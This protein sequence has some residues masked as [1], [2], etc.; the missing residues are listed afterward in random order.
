MLCL[1]FFKFTCL[2][3]RRLWPQQS[4]SYPEPWMAAS[5]WTWQGSPRVDMPVTE[6]LPPAGCLHVWLCW[7]AWHIC[8]AAVW[9]CHQQPWHGRDLDMLACRH[10]RHYGTPAALACC[11]AGGLAMLALQQHGRAR[12]PW[13]GC[14]PVSLTWPHTIILGTTGAL[15]CW[16][17]VD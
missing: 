5:S 11:C 2:W 15:A 12:I 10:Q 9:A 13:R 4:R 7:L 8:I 14:V 6:P 17:A 3:W 16:R 1:S